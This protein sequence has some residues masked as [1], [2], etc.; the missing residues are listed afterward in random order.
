MSSIIQVAGMVTIVVGVALL[1]VPTAVII[2]GVF[3]L[4]TGVA[5]S[6]DA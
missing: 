5:V 3:A 6:R 1:H 4:V 2:A